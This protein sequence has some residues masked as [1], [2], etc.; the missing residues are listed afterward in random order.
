MDRQSIATAVTTR[1]GA[2]EKI[3]AVISGAGVDNSY[4]PENSGQYAQFRRCLHDIVCR[5]MIDSAHYKY[6]ELTLESFSIFHHDKT[7]KRQ[8]PDLFNVNEKYVEIAE[9]TCTYS[10]ESS[11]NEKVTKY[12]DFIDSLRSNGFTVDFS[13]ICVDLSD[14]E[15]SDKIPRI[16]TVFI[17]LIEDMISAL[18][19][20]HSSPKI[21]SLR[22][23]EAGIY[24]VDRF[25]FKIDDR[26]IEDLVEEATNCRMPAALLK[27]KIAG[28]SKDSHQGYI[29]RIAQSI[30]DRPP[31]TRPSPSN[32][33]YV[34]RILI[35]DFARMAAVKPNTSKIPRILQLG[36]PCVLNYHPLPYD[37]AILELRQSGITGGYSDYILNSLQFDC[38]LDD[39]LLTLAIPSSMVEEEQKQG[40]GRKRYLRQKG[41]KTE[42]SEPTHIGISK[43]H[44]SMLDN[45]MDDIHRGIQQIDLPEIRVQDSSETGV[46]SS[47]LLESVESEFRIDKSTGVSLFYQ[48]TANEIVINSMRRRKHNQYA[49]GY[50]GFH[51]IYFLIASGPQLRTENNT[52][53]VKIISIH[54]ALSSGFSAPWHSSG[55][56][57]ESD[58]LSVDTDRLKHWQRARDRTIMCT[59]ANSERLVRPGT[60][61]I[62]ALREE[63]MCR[64]HSLLT[65]MYLENKQSTST[66]NQ[67]IRY[68][69]M[70]SLGDKQ[71]KGL[72]A[73]FP[74]RINSVIQSYMLQRSV[75]SCIKLCKTALSDLVTTAS[76]IRD[77]ETGNYDESTTGV[78]NLMPRLFTN[79][80]P[81]PIS[82]NLNE[83]YWCMLYNKDRQNKTQDAMGILGKI[84]KEEQKFDKEISRRKTEEDKVNYFLGT[85]TISDD[86]EHIHSDQPES[87]YFSYRAV[88]A[89]VAL[90]DVHEENFGE[91][92][93]WLNS[94]KLSKILNKNLSEFA[95]FKASVKNISGVID[96]HDLN[97]VSKLG[98]RTKAIELVAEIVQ[99]EQLQTAS[100]VAMQFS[101]INNK[102]FEIIIQI[103]KKNQ[104]GGVREIIILYIKARILFNIVE[105]IARI[106]S[107]SDRRE[108]LTKGRDKRLMMR[109]DYEHICS[110]FPSG[111]PIQIIKESYDMTTWAQ[112]FIPTIFMP[113]FEHHFEDF[114]GVKDLSKLIFL[115]HSNKKM[116][117][118]KALIEQW[119][120]HPDAKH[121]NTAIQEKKEKFLMDGEPWF[122]NHSNMCQGIPH[123]NSTVLALSC[124]SLRDALFKSCLKK[125]NLQQHIQWR[126]RVGS[127][128]K[129]TIIGIDKSEKDSYYQYMLLGQC[130][131]A[132]ERLHSME[133]SVKSAS[134]HVMYELNSAF[135]A[136]LETLSPTIKFASASVDTIGTTSCSSFVN[137]SYSRIRQMREN[138]CSSLTCSFAHSLNS[139][140]F[141]K[142]F[143]TKI[144]GE[145]DLSEI[146]GTSLSKIPYDF[147]VY[148]TYDI[149]LQD[150]I[151]PEYWNY[152][153]LKLNPNSKPVKLLYTEI[154]K[155]EKEELFPNDSEALMKKDHFGINQGLVRQLDNMRRRL[156]ANANDVEEYF[157]QNP[158]LVVRGPETIEETK[159][160]ILSKLFTK[161]ASESLRRT[162]PA[163]YIGRLSAFRTAKAWTSPFQN[164]ESYNPD[165]DMV[166]HRESF[167][168][169]TYREFLQTSFNLLDNKPPVN[170]E[171]FISV[172][173]P[174]HKSYDVIT[175]FVGKFGALK[176]STKHYSQAVRTWSVNNFNYE[177]NTSLRNIIETSFGRSQES[178]TEDVQEFKKM[179][180]MRLRS[181]DDF[182]FECSEKGIRPLDM[183][184]Y[185]SKIYKNSKSSRIQAFASGPSTSGLHMTASILKKYNHSPGMTVLLDVGIDE[186]DIQ[187]E[188]TLS[189]KLDFAKLYY[190]LILM[191]YSGNMSGD[192][193][194]FDIVLANGSL[195]SEECKTIVRSIKALSGF[196][197]PTQKA[198]KFLACEL[199]E[200]SE[201]REKLISWRMSNYSYI[202]TQRN[203]RTRA[204]KSQ[205]TGE[206]EMLVNSSEDCYTLHEKNNLRY[207]RCRQVTDLPELYRSLREMC[208]V[209][210]FEIST[211]FQSS[212]VSKHDI[213]LSPSTKSLHRA[214]VSGVT[215]M[216]LNI[217]FDS[218]FRYRRLADMQNFKIRRSHDPKTFKLEYYLEDN[219]QR[220]AT[221]CHT[222][223]DY[224]PVE[225]PRCQVN[226]VDVRYLGVSVSKLFENRSW[227]FNYRLPMMTEVA[228][229]EFLKNDVDYPILLNLETSDKKRIQEY[230][231]VRDEVNEESFSLMRNDSIRVISEYDQQMIDSGATFDELF[232]NAIESLE[233]PTS[234]VLHNDVV[235]DWAEE[236]EQSIS[237]NDAI[238]ESIAKDSGN[239]ELV[240]AIGFKRPMAKKAML[241]ING[242]QQ[243]SFMKSRVLDCFFASQNVR[244][245]RTS[246]LANMIIWLTEL[247]KPSDDFTGGN[248]ELLMK[249]ITSHLLR[250]LEVN[251]GV[252]PSKMMQVIQSSNSYG[253]PIQTLYNMTSERPI[254]STDL[255]RSIMDDEEEESYGEEE[256]SDLS[257]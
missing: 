107:K 180:G 223:G 32:D 119:M 252:K 178:T 196:D 191:S 236:V 251:T 128:D 140:H 163:I 137:E 1:I 19:I 166:E 182:K 203:N 215:A 161:G 245:E 59:L 157:T 80:P 197:F 220:S 235:G 29:D 159:Y 150:V 102:N 162:S 217:E 21:A 124:L 84:L 221:I 25:Q 135:M 106:L 15:W 249:S 139:D 71:F 179:I 233:M 226:G 101:G 189:K 205:W 9:V 255:L 76:L 99:S 231:E 16:S 17:E 211:F 256:D 33:S 117:Y 192:V 90:Q 202:K 199:L 243:G 130:E 167:I 100:E 111:T 170:F 116:E 212:V 11:V 14:P 79:G 23:Q 6:E 108:I 88:Q 109:A 120:K 210:G 136:N 206:L 138:G 151:G 97:E 98:Q 250:S 60:K 34:P 195:L 13:V 155:R 40:P 225:L 96:P 186:Y 4:I 10:P 93:S 74:Q 171:N 81:V 41:I 52:I 237:N 54:P 94:L 216:K 254:I 242:L 83:I 185:M 115:S 48:M 232:R 228:R 114:P 168:K 55:N 253:I 37:K 12:S 7:I 66:T 131:H 173:Y 172:M 154:N 141:Y 229:M 175:A 224:Y 18:R 110:S 44:I 160:T 91:N 244:N 145:N 248:F 144:G 50:T 31:T 174:Q 89:G 86:I 188:T 176:S 149:D 73:K 213:Y 27:R 104:I 61:M 121:D 198:L 43:M 122:V 56:H 227:F 240:N 36:S 201:L 129:G 28:A 147:G 103:F 75:D 208:R 105:E 20:M 184:Y 92:G 257:D 49:L 3:A 58:W 67:T 187:D 247:R 209:T 207:L 82:Y 42:R 2:D 241:T 234:L 68:M 142:I 87:H 26:T 219:G 5:S 152:R 78:A 132:S 183:F 85:T 69:W 24:S 200:S 46:H 148:P 72:I 123:Y 164:T 35:D 118:P 133:L 64:N 194:N 39:R 204:G 22:K 193:Q 134:G 190:N 222:N 125:L 53:F 239:I 127:D 230:I 30:I 63:I 77:E 113:L 65:L 181:L 126:T 38:R 169:T 146:M 8:K 246:Q 214:G 165:T 95:T 218:K 57:W 143:D 153:L 112:K 158:F 238:L 47:F 62:Q 45:F 177:Y 156:N 70:K 51:G